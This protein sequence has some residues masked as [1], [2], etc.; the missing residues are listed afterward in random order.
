VKGVTAITA[1][2]SEEMGIEILRADESTACP[3]K[4]PKKKIK[5]RMKR[6]FKEASVA[7]RPRGSGSCLLLTNHP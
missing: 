6:F 5:A 4:A 1:G 3:K 2:L 7:A